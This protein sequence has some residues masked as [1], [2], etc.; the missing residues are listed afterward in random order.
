MAS[1]KSILFICGGSIALA[2]G[3]YQSWKAIAPRDENDHLVKDFPHAFIATVDAG[4]SEE[5]KIWRG[6]VPPATIDIDGTT[7]F[8]A[9]FCKNSHCPGRAG[10]TPYVFAFDSSKGPTALCPLCTTAFHKAP[11]A[12]RGDFDPSNTSAYYTPEAQTLITT[13]QSD[14]H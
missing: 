3:L 13:I 1:T 10:E 9:W 8:P 2:F 7:C 5:V 11:E 14:H 4:R 12:N 6:R